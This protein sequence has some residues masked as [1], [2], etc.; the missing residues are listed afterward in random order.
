MPSGDH[1]TFLES[2]FFQ[3]SNSPCVLPSPAEVREAAIRVNIASHQL[4]QGET[5]EKRWDSLTA[6]QKAAFREQL[7]SMV[8]L[9]R[10]LKQA[11]S[12]QFI[13]HIARQPLHD[14]IFIANSCPPA[15]PFATV[16]DFHDWFAWLPCRHNP[17]PPSAVN[18]M[19]QGL[20]DNADIVF[21]HGDLHRSNILIAPCPS[22]PGGLSVCAIVDWQQAGWY[23]EYW[24]YAKARGTTRIGDE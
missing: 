5:L 24:E 21:S 9:L 4:V 23:P 15:G 7:R 10:K 11:Q 20:P 1:M 18:P 6:E 3:S 17:N 13:G 2:S 16:R 8:V 19:R 14:V 22:S 12:D